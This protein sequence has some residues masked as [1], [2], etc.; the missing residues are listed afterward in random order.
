MISSGHRFFAGACHGFAATSPRVVGP[1]A[2]A[3]DRSTAGEQSLQSELTFYADHALHAVILIL[4][5]AGVIG[6]VWRL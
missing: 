6:R 1:T 5:E 3:A 4:V 2:A